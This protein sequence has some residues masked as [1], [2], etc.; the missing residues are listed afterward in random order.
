MSAPFE[1]RLTEAAQDDIARL[2]DFLLPK[3]PAAA[4]RLLLTIQAAF[5]RLSHAPRIG[6]R[7]PL[8]QELRELV[9]RFGQSSYVCLYAARPGMIVVVRIHH[10]RED[11]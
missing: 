4:A 2:H 11:R 3:N 7:V 9:V 8:S 5:E 1:V 10:A 6:R